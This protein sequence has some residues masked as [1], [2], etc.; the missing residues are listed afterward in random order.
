[1]VSGVCG[2]LLYWID[3]S[4]VFYQARRRE[5]CFIAPF[6]SRPNFGQVFS[7][8]KSSEVLFDFPTVFS[9]CMCAWPWGKC[10]HVKWRVQ[11]H[12]VFFK[13]VY[14]LLCKYCPWSKYCLLYLLR[15]G[16]RT[17]CPESLEKWNTQKLWY[18]FTT[19]VW[20]LVFQACI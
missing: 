1:M 18:I 6:T 10:P 19:A 12:L 15:C 11:P 16:L 2:F 17:K 3:F 4:C 20:L 7:S 8:W 14:S 5:Q 13:L 9:T